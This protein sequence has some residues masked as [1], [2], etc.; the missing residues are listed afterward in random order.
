MA[1]LIALGSESD[2]DEEM[3]ALLLYET[4]EPQKSVWKGEYMK[5]RKTHD[6][7]ALTSEFYDKQF[8]I[9]FRLN[10]SQFNEVHRLVQNS[11]YS[12]G[13]NAQNPTRTEEKLAAFLRQVLFFRFD[14]LFFHFQRAQ[15][16]SGTLRGACEKADVEMW[17]PALPCPALPL[18][19]SL[20]YS[21]V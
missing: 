16:V 3:D 5:K 1:E 18:N 17:C 21:N 4:S 9:H 8:T 11:T 10:R 6:E 15:T 2:S 12:E 7:F 20:T 14:N 19:Y 13:C